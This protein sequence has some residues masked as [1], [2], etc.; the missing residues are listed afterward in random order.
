MK[1]PDA[2]QILRPGAQWVMRGSNLEWLDVVQLRPTDKEIADTIAAYSYREKRRREYPPLEDQLDAM[3][4]GGTDL[5]E[6][7]AT[8]MAVK[9]KYPKPNEVQ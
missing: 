9:A 5:E 8:V 2:L 1:I 6:M 3:W 4:K 7:R